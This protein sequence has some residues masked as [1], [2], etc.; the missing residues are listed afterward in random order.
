MS[1]RRRALAL[2]VALISLT[3]GAKCSGSPAWAEP[4]AVHPTVWACVPTHTDQTPTVNLTP[5]DGAVCVPF[6]TGTTAVWNARR[7]A[8]L[9]ASRQAGP[10]CYGP[11]GHRA[12]AAVNEAIRVN[13]PAGLWES[14]CDT[15]WGE[16]RFDPAARNRCCSGVFQIHAGAHAAR[17]AAHGW[18]AAD[19][20]DP[21]V[22]AT[23]A[24]EVFDANGGWG[25]WDASSHRSDAGDLP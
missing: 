20:F 21:M 8:A 25:P 4:P 19:L 14:A 2:G 5:V 3:T 1:A 16:S 15:A 22:N 9:E 6:A 7:A 17:L 18:T 11:M 23:I 13:F 10:H 24:R 12:G